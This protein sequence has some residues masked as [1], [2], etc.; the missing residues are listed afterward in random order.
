[1]YQLLPPLMAA[2]MIGLYS[3]GPDIDM[4]NGIEQI[5]SDRVVSGIT[6]INHA[7][8]QFLEE[9]SE[10]E[11]HCE[12]SEEG[13][14][15][16]RVSRPAFVPTAEM[17]LKELLPK[18]G[19][20]PRPPPGMTWHYAIEENGKPYFCFLGETPSEKVAKGLMQA[21]KRLSS[22]QVVFSERCGESSGVRSTLQEASQIT[23]VT[24]WPSSE[25]SLA[26]TPSGKFNEQDSTTSEKQDIRDCSPGHDQECRPPGWDDEFLPPGHL[27]H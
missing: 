7:W 23:S 4:S 9:H 14:A 26:G 25:K 16:Q 11:W 8:E 2:A 10:H 24:Y 15:C 27:N 20:V 3:M 17:W 19:F 21:K 5:T 18:Y 6:V 13:E 1:M 12:L 22:D